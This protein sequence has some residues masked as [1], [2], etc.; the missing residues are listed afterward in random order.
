M[1]MIPAHS[2]FHDLLP[3]MMDAQSMSLGSREERRIDWQRTKARQ[4]IVRTVQQRGEP[5][6]YSRSAPGGSQ[7]FQILERKDKGSKFSWDLRSL[8]NVPV[9][10]ILA[11]PLPRAAIWPFWTLWPG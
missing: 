11:C 9:R 3:N 7:V 8:N 2:A 1:S 5:L 6:Y 4:S 10:R